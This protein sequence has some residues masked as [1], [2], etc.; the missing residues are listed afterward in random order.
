VSKQSIPPLTRP[1][2]AWVF[3]V[4][5]VIVVAIASAFALSDGG[6]RSHVSRSDHAPRRWN[7]PSGVPG[8]AIMLGAAA[9]AAAARNGVVPGSIHELTASISGDQLLIAQ[10]A[11]GRLCIAVR[12]KTFAT[13]FDCLTASSDTHAVLL[14]STEGGKSGHTLDH[15]SLVGIA[16]PDVARVVVSKASGATR[17][18]ILNQWRAFTYAATTAAA[19]PR[20]IVAYDAAGNELQRQ[21]LSNSAPG[22]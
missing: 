13:G 18:L 22:Y 1:R 4:A 3:A 16:R 6:G 19:L 14:Y 9:Q 11:D 20:T 15:M 2:A 17:T 12:N 5:A 21:R 8:R 10:R 7:W